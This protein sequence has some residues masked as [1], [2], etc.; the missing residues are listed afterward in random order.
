MQRRYVIDLR[1]TR[2]SNSTAEC[3]SEK[4]VFPQRDVKTAADGMYALRDAIVEAKQYFDAH[5]NLI[6]LRAALLCK[7]LD[8]YEGPTDL[9]DANSLIDI[10]PIHKV[11]RESWATNAAVL[12]ANRADTT[13]AEKLVAWSGDDLSLLLR[14]KTWQWPTSTSW[15]GSSSC[16]DLAAA[17]VAID[18]LPASVAEHA[19][20]RS[21]RRDIEATLQGFSTSPPQPLPPP[22]E[23]LG[24]SIA[25]LRADWMNDSSPLQRRETV[26]R[27]DRLR[28]KREELEALQK[29]IDEELVGDEGKRNAALAPDA[30]NQL[31][32]VLQRTSIPLDAATPPRPSPRGGAE[33]PD[34]L[35]AET[36]E[37]APDVVATY[38]TDT[39]QLLEAIAN[40][41]FGVTSDRSPSIASL[42]MTRLK[43]YATEHG[44]Q[45]PASVAQFKKGNKHREGDPLPQGYSIIRVSPV[46][47]PASNRG[48]PTPI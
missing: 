1:R 18:A 9:K 21:V 41:D 12:P 26:L 22:T 11:M 28:K 10:S 40:N 44:L 23:L 47:A 45:P 32:E 30:M 16:L 37:T 42:P 3:R 19:D 6:D 35:G 36:P 13:I 34:T 33:T 5:E 7:L 2:F 24:R 43:E 14:G 48:E 27:V 17:C 25:L 46:Q 29:S 8:V 31:A 15:R 4:S 20:V 38:P 39:D